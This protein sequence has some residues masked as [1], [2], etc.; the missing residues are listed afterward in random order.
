MTKWNA[1]RWLLALLIAGVGGLA[2]NIS[3]ADDEPKKDAAATSEPATDQE[4][5]VEP[6]ADDKKEAEN[7]YLVKDGS[8]AELMDAIAQLR[9][10]ENKPQGA[11]RDERVANFVNLQ[12]AIIDAAE[13]VLAA[14]VE[15]DV[16]AKAL[17]EQLI[18][19]AYQQRLKQQ[20][21]KQ[22][23]LRVIQERLKDK[24]P[25][26]AAEARRANAS[27][28]VDHLADLDAQQREAVVADLKEYFTGKEPSQDALMA[29]LDIG[30]KLE[31]ADGKLAAGLYRDLSGVFAKS[32]VPRVRE[33]AAKME[34]MARRLELP[35]QF[36]AIDGK[37]VDGKD[38]DW[39]AYR[40]KVVLVDFWATW[41]GPCLREL[42]NVK[43]QYELY[44][45]R[46]FDVV[47]VSLDEDR[48]KLEEFLGKEQLPWTTLFSDDEAA[49]GWDHPMANQYGVTAIPA[50]F[51][52]DKDGKVVT[53]KAR[54]EALGEELAKLL[55]PVEE[56]P[57]TE[58][59]DDAAAK[60]DKS[61][62]AAKQ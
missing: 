30:R 38:F 11:N 48:A 18:S 53:M 26:V 10:Q 17:A 16:A 34:G 15:E 8:P 61:E 46:G 28:Q 56:P 7:P 36:M 42:P 39:S 55:G 22:R 49:T 27:E 21:A 60:P 57:A 37:S 6:D 20:D 23:L 58:D 3:R 45:D 59:A 25:K 33:Y 47:G 62:A 9:E 32:D 1:S 35:G 13:R 52:V 41:C 2:A 50:V 24:R 54:G 29:A 40:G 4:K 43:K 44:H 19:L 31:R 51:L 5:P 12:E 14:Q